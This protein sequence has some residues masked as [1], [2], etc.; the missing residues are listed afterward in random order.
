MKENIGLNVPFITRAGNN[1]L[2]NNIYEHIIFL[3]NE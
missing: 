3:K 2:Y 1:K